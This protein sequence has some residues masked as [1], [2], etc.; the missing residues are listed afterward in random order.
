MTQHTYTSSYPPG[1]QIDE[2]IKTFFEEFYRV[3]DTPE[4]H[5]RY[6]ENFTEDA[7]LVMGSKKG[8]GRD[9]MF[10]VPDSS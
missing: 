3:S 5:E 7:V 9:G 2:G 4:A 6:V 1:I 8:V 10:L